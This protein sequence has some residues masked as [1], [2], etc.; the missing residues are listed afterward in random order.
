MLITDRRIA[1]HPLID[2][3]RAAITAGF[4]SV[5]IREKDLGGRELLELARPIHAACLDS[6]A[7]CLINDRLDVA[8]ALEGAGAHVGR[9]GMPVRDARRLL[10]PTRLLGYSAH[11]EQEA[12]E[13]LA[14]GADYVTL[15]PVFDS[16]SKSGLVGRGP[17]WFAGTARQLGWDRVV[18]LGGVTGKTLPHLR[19]EGPVRAAVCGALM[20]AP[21]PTE[22]AREL[23]R[24]SRPR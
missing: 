19:A 12:S 6:G 4:R 24:E 7:L 16:V 23:A 5:M 10:G 21:D 15:S 1:A 17:H 14:A 11:D 13:A 18:A 3:S 22:A 2:V 8:L 9:H 20:S